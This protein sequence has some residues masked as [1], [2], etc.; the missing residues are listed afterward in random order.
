MEIKE[1]V[2]SE[3][4]NTLFDLHNPSCDTKAEFNKFYCFIVHSK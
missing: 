1:G 4:D 3:V 2:I